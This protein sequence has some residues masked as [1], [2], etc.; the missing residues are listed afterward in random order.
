MKLYIT[1]KGDPHVGIFEQT[2]E[3]ETPLTEENSPADFKWF[4]TQ[5]SNLYNEF[6]EGRLVLIF[7]NEIVENDEQFEI[8]STLSQ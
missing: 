2:Y 8:L 7:A 6:A 5:I 1:D 3:I 4:K